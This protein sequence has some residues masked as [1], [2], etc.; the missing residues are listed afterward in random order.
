M[1]FAR[2]HF[3]HLAAAAIAAPALPRLSFAQEPV[4]GQPLSGKGLVVGRAVPLTAEAPLD[5]FTTWITPNDRFPILTS[6]AQS[7]PQIAPNDWRLTVAGLTDQPLTLTYEQLRALPAQR[8]AA[9]VECAGNSRNTVSPPFARSF[10]DNGYV[11]N[12]EWVGISLGMLLQQAGLKPGA[13]EVV[14]EGADRGRPPASAA[15]VNFAKSVPIEKAIHPDTL[16]VYQMN[17]APLP[18]EYGGPVRAL[19][20]GWYGTYQVKWLT[21][22]EVIDHTFDGVLM[23]RLWRVRRKSNGFLRDEPV[24]QIAVKSLITRP[25]SGTRLAAGPQVISGIAWSGGKDVASVRVSTD[26]GATWR[27]AQLLGPSGAYAWRL[28]ELPWSPAAGR[29]T[30]MARATDTSGAAQPLAY[31]PDLNGY[32]VNQVQPVPVE[33]QG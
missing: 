4:V 9:L 1:S 12:A 2:R 24:S 33:V 23:T 20:P 17:G 3:L 31:D 32:E 10:L 25:G 30:L 28:W 18:R 22:V 13:V 29:Y 26:A 6:I 14:L 27:L 15:D 8:I 7:L 16:L 11:G 5:S 19:V 21:R